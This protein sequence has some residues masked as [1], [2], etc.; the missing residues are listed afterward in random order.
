VK[1]QKDQGLYCPGD[2]A[3]NALTFH[4]EFV[5]VGAGRG[6]AAVAED[7]HGGGDGACDPL[8]IEVGI[9]REEWG[10]GR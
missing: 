3:H 7:L 4:A 5:A 6:A 8:S 9:E 2:T 1:G 10:V